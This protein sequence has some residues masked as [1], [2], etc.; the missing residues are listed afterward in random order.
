MG[1]YALAE[2]DSCVV[3]MSSML[4]V[5]LGVGRIGFYKFYFKVKELG[6]M[7]E[8]GMAKIIFQLLNGGKNSKT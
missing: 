4:I 1:N 2:R 7:V 5:R 8:F 3:Q 6:L